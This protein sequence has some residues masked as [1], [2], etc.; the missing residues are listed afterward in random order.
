VQHS[1][2]VSSVAEDLAEGLA[3][4]GVPVNARLC[5]V[6]AALHDIGKARVPE[7]LSQPGHRHPGEG[8]RLLLE[9]GQPEQIARFARDHESWQSISDLE[10]LIVCLADALWKGTRNQPLEERCLDAAAAAAGRDRWELYAEVME[11][12]DRVADE[13]S[14]RL[15]GTMQD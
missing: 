14:R 1:E 9:L 4:L 15:S 3:A 8:Y 6:G 11:L 13:G 12:F 2:I 7:E 10:G 5:A